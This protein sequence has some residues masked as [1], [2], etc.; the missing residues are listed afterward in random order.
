M[1][2]Q[3]FRPYIYDRLG[4]ANTDNA[5]PSSVLNNIINAALRQLSLEHDWSW[6]TA[7]DSSFT[8]TAAGTK[9]YTPHS[10]WRTTQYIVVDTDHLLKNKQPADAARYSNFEG[11]PQFYSIEGGTIRLFP[12]PDAV[13]DVRHVFTRTEPLL[14]GD[15]DEPLMPDWAIDMLVLTSAHIA[16][17]RLR[18]RDLQ[19][20]LKP[21]LDR[22]MSSIKDEVRRTRS[23]VEPQHRRDIGWG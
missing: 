1:Q 4:M 22:I 20:A 9:D 13:Y 3:V 6:L 19:A 10:T 2:L 12:T 23:P 15:T 7:T 5:L 18:D 14:T 17:G 21:E 11:Y 8:A 16:A